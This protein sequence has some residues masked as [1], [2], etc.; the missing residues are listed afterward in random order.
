MAGEDDG[1]TTNGNGRRRRRTRRSAVRLSKLYSYAC[2]RRP[3]VADDHSVSKIG[4]PGFSRVVLVNAAAGE[5]P[6]AADQQQQQQ[7]TA[8]SNSIATTKYNLFTFLP[9]SLFEQFRRVANI[10]FLLSAGI[11]YSPLAAYSSSS[12]I[13]PLVIV[14]VATMIKEAI[15]DWRRNQQ[16]RR[17]RAPGRLNY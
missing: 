11:A 9:K 7:I 1:N 5:P 16:V 15:E 6:A 2:G 10:Y 4:G 13:A 12:A 8:S 14:L 3:S 17:S